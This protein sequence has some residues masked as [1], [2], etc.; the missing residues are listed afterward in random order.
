MYKFE[1]LRNQIS[2]YADG[3]VLSELSSEKI[4]M[5]MGI[6]LIPQFLEITAQ[7]I[8]LVTVKKF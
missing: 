2:I 1:N 7:K 4:L 3:A 8:I 6:P 5:W